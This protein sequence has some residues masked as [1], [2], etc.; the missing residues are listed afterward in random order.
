MSHPCVTSDAMSLQVEWVA[1]GRP[2]AD[3]PT[4]PSPTPRPV[5]RSRR[6][7][8]WCPRTTWAWRVVGC[9]PP[10][11]SGQSRRRHR[12][13]G[14]QLPHHLPPGRAPRR[15]RARRGRTTTG[16]HARA[17]GGDAG[18]ARCR[19]RPVRS[20]GRAPGHRV[21]AGPRLPRAARP[22]PAALDAV[23]RTSSRASEVVR[24][25]CAVL[26]R[27]APRWSD[28]Q[29]LLEAAA[30]RAGPATAGTRALIVH[31]PS[32]SASTALGCSWRWPSTSPPR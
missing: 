1:Y 16:V 24:L 17:R 14:R 20:G 27:L 12:P 22:L 15:S 13:G 10:A 31:L 3:A 25:H 6:S 19:A 8:S 30:E 9:S 4:A 18:R 28:E 26:A 7:R 5:S 29:D 21:R 32:G 23:A 11:R 2:A